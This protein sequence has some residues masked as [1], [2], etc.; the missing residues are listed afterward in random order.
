M[1]PKHEDSENVRLPKSVTNQARRMGEAEDRGLS[2]MI[3]HAWRTFVLWRKH[4][5]PLGLFEA[6]EEPEKEKDETSKEK[7]KRT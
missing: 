4:I 2:G 1:P 3:A 6:G 7:G 5:R